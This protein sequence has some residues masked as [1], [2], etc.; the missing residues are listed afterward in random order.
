METPIHSSF[1]PT[2][3]AAPAPSI[4]YGKSFADIAVLLGLI[5]LIIS[6]AV[7]VG[8]FLYQQYATNAL[9]TEK[10]QLKLGQKAFSTDAV[11]KLMRLDERLRLAEGILGAHTAPS[12]L[13]AILQET[14]LKSIQFT[15]L[16]YQQPSVSEITV[17]M[18][19]K[20]RTVNAIA[21]QANMF[22]RH[23]AIK[24]PIFQVNEFTKDGVTFT[25]TMHLNADVIRFQSLIEASQQV[26]QRAQQG[27]TQTTVS[28]D[29]FSNAEPQQSMQN[30]PPPVQQASG[31]RSPQRP[32]VSPQ[33]QQKV[34]QQSGGTGGGFGDFGE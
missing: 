22:S 2:Q 25:V 16:E 1:I 9:D 4:E 31:A 7:S 30:T 6:G 10:E 21:L 14:T 26:A 32:Q 15:S 20:A 13:F 5:A 27:D 17:T 11:E 33:T 18:H 24:D 8:V 29:D 12:V 19:G 23:Q 34:P 28:G 3:D